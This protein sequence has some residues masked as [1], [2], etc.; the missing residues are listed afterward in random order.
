[1]AHISPNYQ[2]DTLIFNFCIF[3]EKCNLIANV[4]NVLEY[5]QLISTDATGSTTTAGRFRVETGDRE[6][7]EVH[8]GS[9]N[10]YLK[11]IDTSPDQPY[12]HFVEC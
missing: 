5:F 9:V 7:D 10:V 12:F 3:C 8:F 1:M 6:G 2:Q 4:Y 11:Y